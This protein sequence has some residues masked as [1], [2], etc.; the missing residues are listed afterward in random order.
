M[1]N[2]YEKHLEEVRYKD[3]F[4]CEILEGVLQYEDEKEKT[5]RFKWKFVVGM[6]VFLLI[7]A[8]IFFV[9]SG[10]QNDANNFVIEA[11]DEIFTLKKSTI[12]VNDINI[13]PASM[14]YSATGVVQ[15]DP[16][17]LPLGVYVKGD[18]IESITFTLSEGE[19]YKIDEY[20]YND[21]YHSGLDEND[22]KYKN[23]GYI[24]CAKEKNTFN[25]LIQGKEVLPGNPTMNSWRY[26]ATKGDGKQI[27]IPYNEQKTVAGLF[28]IKF[29]FVNE[30]IKKLWDSL[31]SQAEAYESDLKQQVEKVLQNEEMENKSMKV[32]EFLYK[33]IQN[34]LKETTLEV[35]VNYT[36]GTFETTTLHFSA[37]ENG[38]TIK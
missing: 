8:S 34:I 32:R 35:K 15:T 27:T 5:S 16:L 7:M 23:N 21:G 6:G 12:E 33:D 18:S 30:E 31:K 17:S 37:D 36:D 25:E 2:K 22:E 10:K 1:K 29:T 9:K 19:F 14:I 28:G 11:N 20:Q 4:K 26:L 24:S 3:N 38:T 13:L